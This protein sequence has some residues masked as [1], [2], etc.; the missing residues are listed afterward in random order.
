MKGYHFL[1][2]VLPFTL[3]NCKSV[4][5]TSATSLSTQNIEAV[6]STKTFQQQLMKDY[7][8]CRCITI[9]Y[10]DVPPIENDISVSL[11]HEQSLYSNK[12]DLKIDSLARVVALSIKPSEYPDYKGKRP[13]LYFCTE[14]YKSKALDSLVRALD[15][16]IMK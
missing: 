5:K 1:C 12:A 15:D 10:K 14:F 8:L 11:Y 3:W 9:A 2:F 4:K 16:Q 7:A 6:D 13:I